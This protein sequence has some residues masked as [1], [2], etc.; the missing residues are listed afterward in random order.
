MKF[1]RKILETPGYHTVK[2]EFAI[3]PG[4][5]TVPGLTDR[6]TDRQTNRITIANTR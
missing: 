4:L 5:E 3:S 2:T 1:C 6:Q